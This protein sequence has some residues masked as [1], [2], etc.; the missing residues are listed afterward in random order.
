MDFLN[1]FY[2]QLVELTRAMTPRARIAA[3]AAIAIVV[4]G[5]GYFGRSE[6]SV[7]HVYLLGGQELSAS[8]VTAMQGA[9]GKAKLNEFVVE[10]NRIRVPRAKQAA[11]LAAL[12]DG[13]ALPQS[14]TDVFAEATDKTNWF[15]SRQQQLDQARIAKKKALALM[16]RG[17]HGVENADVDFDKEEPR[18][19]RRDHIATAFVALRLKAGHALDENRAA[20]FQRTVAAA[21]GMAPHDVTVADKVNLLIFGGR[22]ATG[23]A[24]DVYRD[25]KRKY[26]AD[27]EETVRKA[28]MYVPGIT[29]SADVELDRELHREERRI[30]FDANQPA[31][32]GKVSRSES[33][34]LADATSPHSQTKI[35]M[36]G[37]TPKRVS[38]SV[39][40]PVTYF[41][42]V[43]RQRNPAAP[44]SERSVA[45]VGELAQL[46]SEEIA[47]IKQHVAGLIPTTGHAIAGAAVTVTPFSTVQEP[48]A[49]APTLPILMLQWLAV[50]W[51]Q[52]ATVIAIFVGLLMLRSTLRSVF[53]SS[54]KRA[55]NSASPLLDKGAPGANPSARFRAAMA[56]RGAAG[57][58]MRDEVADLVREDP[59]AAASVLRSWI[60]NAN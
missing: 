57:K 9:L 14:L 48:E 54:T 21:L 5:L 40:V 36:A 15:T 56:E 45:P 3:A 23:P 20:F 27:Y 7:D 17:M 58:S 55:E 47:R 6:F 18:G 43:W 41:E 30:E 53:D 37:L 16:L 26:Q 8:E 12:A 25:L 2:T 19:L 50:S 60:G 39:G 29:V 46:Q 24:D 10:G 13:N 11:Y 22:G 4:L 35:E 34:A 52:V 38:I 44:L 59:A 51:M 32:L 49:P 28:L 31:N 33:V 1:R 42:T